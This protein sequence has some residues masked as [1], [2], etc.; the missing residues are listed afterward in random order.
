MSVSGGDL[1]YA[2]RSMRGNPGFAAV[3]VASIALGIGVNTAVF[4]LVDQAL[5]WSIPARDPAQLVNIQGGRSETYPFYRE[6]RDHNQVF[7]AMFASS[8]PRTVGVRPEGAPAVEVAHMSYVSGN[9]FRTLGVG[10]AVGRVL[11]DS[12]DLK[13]GGSQVAVLSYKYWQ[14]RMGGDARVVGRKIA[15]NGYPLEIVG[16]A[17]AA[18]GGIF[19]GWSADAFLPLTLYPL[20]NPGAAPVWNTPGM[21]WLSSMGRL[22]P[23]V[24]V[25]QAQAAMRVLRAQAIEA[26]NDSTVK[27]GGKARKFDHDDPITV[28]PGARGG[29]AEGASGMDPL[30]ALLVATGLVLLIACGNVANLL[31]ARAATRRKEIA[32]RLAMG[33]TRGRL[34]RQLLTES[35]VLA[36]IGGAAGLALAYWSVAAIANAGLVRADIRLQPSLALA[37]FA[38]GVTALTGI[39]FGLAPALRVTRLDLSQACKDGGSQGESRVRLGKVLIA[40]QAA[41]SLAL[42][43]G[44]GLFIRTLRNLESVDLGFKRENVVILDVDPSNLG[45]RG[46][47]LRVFY[48]QLLERAR[49]LPGVRSAALVGMTPMGQFAMSRSYS[50]EGYQPRPG[51]TLIAYANP[52]SEGYFTTLGIPILLGRDFRPRDEPAV[53]PQDG[54]FAAL[55]RTSG[56]GSDMTV[57]NASPVCIIN[58]SLA[59]RLFGDGNPVGRHLSYFDEYRPET[60]VEIVGVVKDVR[61]VSIRH[62]DREGIIYAPSWSGGAEAR[63]LVV[64]TPRSTA[65]VAAA[66]RGELRAMD[67]NVPLLGVEKLGDDVRAHL[68]RERMIAWLCG[69]FGALALALAAVGLY[70]V[71]AYAVTGRTREVGIR[72]ALGAQ[73]RDVVRMVVRESLLPVLI[74]IAVGLAGALAASRLVA[75]LLFG[76]APRDPLSF[77]LAAAALFAVALAAAALPARRASRVEPLIALRYE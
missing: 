56:G 69:S 7:S 21:Y 68:R 51:E 53:T 2:L 18:F 73:R 39:L 6:Y 34:I 52:V 44:A 24:S 9:Y 61:Q 4:S 12:D 41:L 16:I 47:R 30:E 28:T 42:L 19:N 74:G 62:A 76:V 46:H 64:R 1:R 20:T 29:L 71:M 8:P 35:L 10:A 50:A 54:L 72:M 67:P 32:V 58:E 59:R 26:V 31:L 13:P 27:R 23:G 33:A 36:F 77:F 15:V 40:G 66:I 25:A 14:S 5:L 60:G 55:G 38:I 45:Y 57:P 63:Y 48:D 70:G 49:R 65:P 17:E 75:S 3:A 22:K 43:V 11:L 37:G